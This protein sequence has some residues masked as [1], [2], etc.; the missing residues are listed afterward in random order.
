MYELK[1]TVKKNNDLTNNF[2][3]L[4]MVNEEVL[5]SEH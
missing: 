5:C 4:K 2:F 1:F 3:P